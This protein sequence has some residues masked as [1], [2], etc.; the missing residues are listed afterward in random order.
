VG[1]VT[2]LLAPA[3]ATYHFALLWLPV[4]LLVNHQIRRGALTRA[5]FIIAAYAA[6]G[7]FPYGLALPFDGRGG[8]SVLA[9]PRLFLL[10]AIFLASLRLEKAR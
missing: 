6:I 7:F 10:L 2:L 5:A 4:A 1:V 3:T 8:L 9:Y